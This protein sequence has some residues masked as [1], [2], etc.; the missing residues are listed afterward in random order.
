[1][2]YIYEKENSLDIELCKKIIDLFEKSEKKH[3]GII[4]SGLSKNIKNTSDLHFNSE[5]DLFED[6]DKILYIELNKNLYYYIDKINEKCKTL[7][8][9]SF[10]DSGF[11]IQKYIKNE[12]KYIYHNDEYITKNT[13]RI[14]TY[15]WYLNDVD[16]GGET[17]FFGNYKIKPK[18]GKLVIFPASWTFPHCGLTPKSNDKYILTGWIHQN[19]K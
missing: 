4:I 1:M 19:L 12:G 5:K 17:E 8:Y 18:C 10:T 13:K 16:D 3:D 9:E 6:I 2:E 7:Q 14:L 11:N 15:I